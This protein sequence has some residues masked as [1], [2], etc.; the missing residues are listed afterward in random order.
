M[1]PKKALNKNI[2]KAAFTNKLVA[3]IKNRA[4]LEQEQALQ[5][6][7]IKRLGEQGI[8]LN[9]LSEVEA[10]FKERL[11][12]AEVEGINYIFL[13]YVNTVERGTLLISYKA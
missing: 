12:L 8:K 13:D 6:E 5:D 10:F 2:N 3:E 11:T 9:T 4:A 7:I 1:I